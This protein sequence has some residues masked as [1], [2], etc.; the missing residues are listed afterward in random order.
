MYIHKFHRKKNSFLHQSPWH[1]TKNFSFFFYNVCINVCDLTV[2]NVVTIFNIMCGI[3]AY[4]WLYS[5]II[6]SIMSRKFLFSFF[7]LQFF[8]FRRSLSSHFL[9]GVLRDCFC[10]SYLHVCQ[11]F[12]G[13]H[14]KF[15]LVQGR[16]LNAFENAKFVFRSSYQSSR[17]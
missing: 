9:L 10:Q 2:I 14:M 4:M 15:A 17:I 1:W 3:Y 16:I 5:Y 11:K 12:Y 13:K 7:L 6:K 8:F